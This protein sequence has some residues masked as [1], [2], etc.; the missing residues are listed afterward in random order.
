M[1]TWPLQEKSRNSLG[2]LCEHTLSHESG[3]VK[4]IWSSRPSGSLQADQRSPRW[5][6]LLAAMPLEAR[7]IVSRVKCPY[8]VAQ[9]D[10][11][12]STTRAG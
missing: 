5:C 6:L 1:A 2:Q 12:A 3:N 11:A 8:S 7:Q 4:Q 9:P 10:K